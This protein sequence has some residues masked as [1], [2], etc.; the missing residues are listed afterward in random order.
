MNNLIKCLSIFPI[1]VKIVKYFIQAYSFNPNF[2]PVYFD[3]YHHFGTLV[4]IFAYFSTFFQSAYLCVK[5]A[6]YF[7]VYICFLHSVLHKIN[8]CIL[9]L[10]CYNCVQCIRLLS[11]L[12]GWRADNIWGR[13]DNIEA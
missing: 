4:I 5:H 1:K 10:L 3:V 7:L 9:N 2:M 13:A 11:S 8:N 12:Y 6:L